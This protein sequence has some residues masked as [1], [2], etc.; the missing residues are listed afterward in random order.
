L[1]LPVEEFNSFHVI[2]AGLCNFNLDLHVGLFG[3][4][5]G[6]EVSI[7]INLH[8]Y[9]MYIH[10]VFIPIDLERVEFL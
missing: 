9:I 8:N 4:E 7:A 10:D 3:P 1:S 2:H 5:S 6:Q